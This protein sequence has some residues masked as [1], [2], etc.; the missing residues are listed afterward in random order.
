M[1]IHAKG[2]AT[3]KVDTLLSAV[4]R[5]S[6]NGDVQRAR[7][8]CEAIVTVVERLEHALAAEKH[9]ADNAPALQVKA[10]GATMGTMRCTLCN[11]PAGTC[12]C[13]TL[14]GCGWSY[15]KG[16]S[17]RNP[18]HHAMLQHNVARGDGVGAGV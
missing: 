17:C 5:H 18:N 3:E 16:T 12:D 4:R 7:N 11:Q 14:C 13:W 10:I 8:C 2:T 1:G 6:A 15:E 9:R